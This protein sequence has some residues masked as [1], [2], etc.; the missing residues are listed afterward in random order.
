MNFIRRYLKREKKI[1]Y[2]PFIK[3]VRSSIIGEGMLHDG[4]I[5]L[6]DYAI[7]NMPE[8]GIILEIGSYAG[9]ST[10]VMLHL[11]E[12]NNKKNLFFGCDPWI[13]EGYDDHKGITQKH[14]DG[15]ANIE[16]TEFMNYIKEAFMKSTQLFHANS[17]PYTCHMTSD[18]FFEKWNTNQK[19]TDVFNRTF[20]MKN[21]ISF[22]YIDGDHSYK[23]TERDFFNVDSKLQ[24]NGF[25]LIDD[26]ISGSKFG[27]AVFIK[28]ILQNPNYKLIDH[29][30]NYL[31]QKINN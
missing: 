15:K 18:L 31:F 5:Y 3:R 21:L 10:N 23:Q 12:K 16:R 30:P 2:D 6:M 26:S 24:K 7:K 17:L 14:I 9:L 28:Q 22:C 8:E 20:Y 27:S 19:F 25:V 29:N 11:L 13:Y 1:K 4:N